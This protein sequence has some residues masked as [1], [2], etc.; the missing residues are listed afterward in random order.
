MSTVHVEEE[1]VS[2]REQ[3]GFSRLMKTEAMLG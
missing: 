3:G 1:A 2:D